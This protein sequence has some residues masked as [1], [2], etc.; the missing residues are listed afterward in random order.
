[1][2][3]IVHQGIYVQNFKRPLLRHTGCL[4]SQLTPRSPLMDTTGLLN[5]QSNQQAN[6]QAST[7]A[8]HGSGANSSPNNVPTSTIIAMLQE[9]QH[10]LQEVI[11]TQQGMLKKQSDFDHKL[12]SLQHE[13]SEGIKS[14]S[15]VASSTDDEKVK[16][17]RDL[18]VSVLLTI[19]KI[20]HTWVKA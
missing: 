18:T 4:A 7:S 9:Q 8:I 10:L 15:S 2:Q 1:M 16:V 17:T 3:C 11:S 13:V 20:L 12:L 5:Q 19:Y 14:C 6:Q